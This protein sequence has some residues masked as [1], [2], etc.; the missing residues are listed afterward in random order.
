[1]DTDIAKLIPVP[2]FQINREGIIL[3]SSNQTHSYF[4]P[5]SN[6]WNVIQ[7]ENQHKAILMLSH[8]NNF[9]PLAQHLVLQ[10][11]NT[12]FI[13]FKCTIQWKNDIGHLVCTEIKNT[14]TAYITPLPVQR[15]LQNTAKRLKQSE[16]HL[17]IV[18]KI[19][20]LRKH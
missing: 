7:K 15:L 5:T 1:M 11:N 20:N 18:A 12:L 2:Y 4:L 9:P 8:H 14:T 13:S 10:T 16:E 3:N 6:I 17:N 19:L